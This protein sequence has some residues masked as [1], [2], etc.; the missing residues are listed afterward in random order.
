MMVEGSN[1]SEVVGGVCWGDE[2]QFASLTTPFTMNSAW[3]YSKPNSYAPYDYLWTATTSAEMG[4]AGTQIL[5]HQNAGGYNNYYGGSGTYKTGETSNNLRG[6]TSAKMGPCYNDEGDTP[7]PGFT[8]NMPCMSDWA[9]Q[10][11]QYSL[12]SAKATTTDKRLAWGADWGSLGYDSLKTINGYTVSGWPKVSYS[13]YVVLDNHAIAPTQA[14]AEQAQVV[15]QTALTA[16]VGTVLTSGPAGVGRTDTMN[17]SPPG[18][19]PV[20][21]T[22]E[23]E[24]QNNKATLTF[25]VSGNASATLNFPIMV[26]HNYTKTTAPTAISYDGKTLKANEGYFVSLRYDQSELWITLF[27][28]LKG[29]HTV[30]ISN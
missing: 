5:A 7:A 8:H 9:Y 2:Y 3:D 29:S 28:R 24:A 18:Y 22:W 4:L 27:E 20:Y 6:N 17:Y 19:S 14:I 16:S 13:V 11:V 1:G 12:A 15:S 23:V 10:L 25:N 30:E 21:G 26:V